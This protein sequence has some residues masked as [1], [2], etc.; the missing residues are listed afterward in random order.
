M[1]SLSARCYRT[2][3]EATMKNTFCIISAALLFAAFLAM[4][5]FLPYAVLIF[6]LFV[7]LGFACRLI[8]RRT[9]GAECPL[10]VC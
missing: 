8:K 6:G 4:N 2:K 9:R 10:G 1:D 5:L 7:S 3:M